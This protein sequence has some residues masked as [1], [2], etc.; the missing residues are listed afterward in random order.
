MA[1]TAPIEQAILGPFLAGV[2]QGSAGESFCETVTG[3]HLASVRT[4]QRVIEPKD[5]L[6]DGQILRFNGP[7]SIPLDISG[8]VARVRC[9]DSVIQPAAVDKSD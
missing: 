8:R 7:D 2:W 3:D 4:C 9:C 1:F 5:L 6:K